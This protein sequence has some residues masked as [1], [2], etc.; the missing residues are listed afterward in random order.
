MAIKHQIPPEAHATLQDNPDALYLDVRTEVEFAA[1]HAPRAINIPVMVAKGPGQMQL[2]IDFV[3]VVVKV[4]PRDKKLIVGCMVGGRS[5]RAC[6][7]LEEAGFIDLINV[8]G[9]F[10]GQ[11]DASGKVVVV[12]WKDAGLPVTTEL[13]EVTYAALRT[14]AGV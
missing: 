5:Q 6:E 8:V 9:G 13:G 11:R 2:N 10:G 14:K 4:I 12:G 1:G 7:M 3:E